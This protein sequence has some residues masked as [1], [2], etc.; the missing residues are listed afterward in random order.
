MVLPSHV[1]S[2]KHILQTQ[3]PKV[4]DMYVWEQGLR[5]QCAPQPQ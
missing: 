1:P 4:M 2:L 3:D 5:G